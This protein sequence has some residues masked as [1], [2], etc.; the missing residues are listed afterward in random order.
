MAKGAQLVVHGREFDQAGQR[1]IGRVRV[2]NVNL[3]GTGGVGG[4]IIA[5]MIQSSIDKKLNPID[6]ISLEKMHFMLP[7]R[8]SAKVRARAT[9]VRPDVGNTVLSFHITYSFEKG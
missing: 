7:I 1:V 2:L 5:R 4:S 3:N 6:I 9:A 8:S